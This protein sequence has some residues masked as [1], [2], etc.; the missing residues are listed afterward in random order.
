MLTLNSLFFS[1]ISIIT[2]P[3]L[4]VFVSQPQAAK[5]EGGKLERKGRTISKAKQKNMLFEKQPSRNK[6]GR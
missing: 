5:G 6:E 1:Y 2:F 3:W 4:L